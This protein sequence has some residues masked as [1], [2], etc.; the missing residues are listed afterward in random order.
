MEKL[1]S[2]YGDFIQATPAEG[3]DVTVTVTREQWTGKE[4]EIVQKLSLIRR[5]VVAGVFEKYLRANRE[6]KVSELGPIEYRST[7]D[8]LVTFTPQERQFTVTYALEFIDKADR[9]LARVFLT[10]FAN[11]SRKAPRAPVMNF[12]ADTIPEKPNYIGTF[13]FIVNPYSGEDRVISTVADLVSSFRNFLHYHIKA[14][15]TYFQSRMR[16]RVVDLVKILN[17]AKQA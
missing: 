15:K 13:T 3:Y 11:A 7:D 6:G 2:V 9:E 12:K 4:D 5:H 14:S 8:T 1:Q 17:R 10:S 16:N